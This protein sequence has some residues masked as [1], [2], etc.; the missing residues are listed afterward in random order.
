MEN[1]ER[2]QWVSAKQFPLVITMEL[3][4]QKPATEPMFLCRWARSN[5]HEQWSRAIGLRRANSATYANGHANNKMQVRQLWSRQNTKNNQRTVDLGS[6][7]KSAQT[8]CKGSIKIEWKLAPTDK[9]QKQWAL[10]IK[11][12]PAVNK[13]R[14]LRGQ[15]GSHQQCTPTSPMDSVQICKISARAYRIT[16]AYKERNRLFP[17]YNVWPVGIK[18]Q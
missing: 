16:Q 7:G 13:C 4:N 9:N 1:L 14:V 10:L 18:R 3:S 11:H 12:L 2:V 15:I 5:E 17:K 6:R 8:P